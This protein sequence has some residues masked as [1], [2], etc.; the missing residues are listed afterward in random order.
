VLDQNVMLVRL[1]DD[2]RTLALADAGELR[3]EKQTVNGGEFLHGM[4]ELFRPAAEEHQIRIS[5]ADSLDCP[6]FQADPDRLTQIFTNLIGN[7]IRYSPEGSEITLSAEC[8]AGE[9]HLSVR[10]G[11]PGIPNE[12]LP[13][14]FDRF[15]RVNKSRSKV[16]GG[17]GLGLAIAR[18]LA[19]VHG[20]R[21]TVENLPGGGT[22]FTLIL[23]REIGM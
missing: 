4:Q 14:I 15:Y 20:G 1:V 2:L 13:F 18:Q 3:L 12:D 5:V 11:G 19:E 10:D 17:S 22:Q 23:P 7:A 16:E 21:L 9:I 6:S 8:K